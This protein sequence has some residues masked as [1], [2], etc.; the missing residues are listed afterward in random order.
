MRLSGEA[1]HLAKVE[2]A[3]VPTPLRALSPNTRFAMTSARVAAGMTQAQLNS[4]V[5]LPVNSIRDF[6]SGR[7]VPTPT[8][9]DK[10]NRMLNVRLHYAHNK[11]TA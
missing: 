4:R 1:A 8:Q 7:A 5:A 11:K 9:L 6:E 10:L 2:R 3:D